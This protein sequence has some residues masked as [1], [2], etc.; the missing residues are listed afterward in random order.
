[1]KSL[2]LVPG[3][4]GRFEVFVGKKQIFSKLKEDRFPEWQE[5]K[6][7]VTAQV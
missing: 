3:D 6:D 5:I 4:G 1:M 7:A 2:E